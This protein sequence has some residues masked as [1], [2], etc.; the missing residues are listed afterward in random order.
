MTHTTETCSNPLMKGMIAVFDGNTY[1]NI[2][3]LYHNGMI[4]TKIVSL[5]LFFRTEDQEKQERYT[6]LH[7]QR[8]IK[9]LANLK[10]TDGSRHD[11]A[12]GVIMLSFKDK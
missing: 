5:K 3:T 8:S 12:L 7:I 4:S 6:A 2:D 10:S 9:F 11:K 1:V